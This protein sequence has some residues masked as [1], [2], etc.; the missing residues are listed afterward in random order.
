MFLVDRSDGLGFNA[1][2]DADQFIRRRQRK[3]AELRELL[4]A[5]GLAEDPLVHVV[6][7]DPHGAVGDSPGT[8]RSDYA[9]ERARAAAAVEAGM[10]ELT[11]LAS[12]RADPQT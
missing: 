11:A 8:T 12:G 9:D 5:T 3:A 6:A 7:S 10:I 4:A 2:W 1:A